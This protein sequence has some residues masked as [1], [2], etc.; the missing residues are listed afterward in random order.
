M[1][2]PCS[3]CGRAQAQLTRK[4][5]PDELLGD[6][7]LFD[8]DPLGTAGAEALL[9]DACAELLHQTIVGE[10]DLETFGRVLRLYLKANPTDTARGERAAK[11]SVF[12]RALRLG[13]RALESELLQPHPHEKPRYAEQLGL[14]GSKAAKLA[15]ISEALERADWS[16][17]RL[18]AAELA[19][20]H[21]FPEV[22][23]LARDLP[24]LVALDAEATSDLDRLAQLCSEAPSLVDRARLGAALHRSM[25]LGLHRRVAD[26]CDVQG[27]ATTA[28][29]HVSGWY[30]L[31]A[32]DRA[33]AKASLERAADAGSAEALVLL[34]NLAS[35]DGDAAVA[36]ELYRR[37]FCLDS[38][39]T[40]LEQIRDPAVSELLDEAR[41]LELEPAGDW[42][43]MVGYAK[44]LFRL[45]TAPDGGPKCRAFHA[46]LLEARRLRSERADDVAARRELRAMA[47]KLF[48]LL[49]DEGRL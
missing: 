15:R 47:P 22:D 28:A 19:A 40:H 37:A 41:E 5:V 8:F 14:F 4:L 35:E 32:E 9:C 45:P 30:W 42:V 21:H 6:D 24:A 36:R 10:E 49:K 12:H 43:P 39:S 3:M 27:P 46:K 20:R 11:H 23:W 1:A 33:R 16:G 48:E 7:G 29:G 38:A 2:P 26:A 17:A 18:L 13:L 44:S 25:V 34:G 31:R